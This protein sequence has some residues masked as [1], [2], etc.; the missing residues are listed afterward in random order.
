MRIERMLTRSNMRDKLKTLEERV[1]TSKPL[2]DAEELLRRAYIAGYKKGVEEALAST[3]ETP[4]PPLADILAEQPLE[5]GD[6]AKDE[7][8]TE[9]N[10]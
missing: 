7:R 2:M 10:Q 9:P 3:K 5:P 1:K 8:S 4:V 6:D